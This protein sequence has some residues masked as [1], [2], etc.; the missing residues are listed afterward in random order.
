M[1]KFTDEELC[2]WLRLADTPIYDR[3][4]EAASRIEELLGE[5]K[6]KE[7]DLIDLVNEVEILQD[8]LSAN[9]SKTFD[10]FQDDL[11]LKL[12]QRR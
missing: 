6:S 3:S 9:L 5:L 4:D 8:N 2:S 10:K 12:E 11:I 1:D 7:E